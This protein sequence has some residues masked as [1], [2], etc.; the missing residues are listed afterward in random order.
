MILSYIGYCNETLWSSP[1][2]DAAVRPCVPLLYMDVTVIAGWWQA[3]AVG[4]LESAEEG[5]GRHQCRGGL[6]KVLR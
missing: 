3:L 5:H 4:S 1:C 2:M 6:P